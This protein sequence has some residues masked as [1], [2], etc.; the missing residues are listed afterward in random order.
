M[1]DLNLTQRLYE[2]GAE[3]AM[4]IEEDHVPAYEFLFDFYS[5]D[6]HFYRTGAVYEQKLMEQAGGKKCYG[7]WDGK[8]QCEGL[9][10]VHGRNTFCRCGG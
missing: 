4:N 5:A 9:C 2:S 3:F 8:K 1:N 6:T 7:F 10:P